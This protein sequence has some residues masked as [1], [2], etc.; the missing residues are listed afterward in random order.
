LAEL[1]TAEGK[2]VTAPQAV[3]PKQ[4]LKP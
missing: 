1:D 3:V 4:P 2:R